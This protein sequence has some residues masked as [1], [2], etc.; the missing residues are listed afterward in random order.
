MVHQELGMRLEVGK[1]IYFNMRPYSK[2]TIYIT[3]QMKGATIVT[4]KNVVAD[5]LGLSKMNT[6]DT[7]AESK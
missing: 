5:A 4:T 7:L 3:G 6:P 1:R 2:T